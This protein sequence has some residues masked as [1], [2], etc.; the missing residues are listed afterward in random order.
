MTRIARLLLVLVAG[1]STVWAS[2]PI[3]VGGPQLG[4]DGE[5]FRWNPAAMPIRYRVDAGPM[6][7]TLNNSAGRTLVQRMFQVW[8]NV[9]TA[10]ISY[11][12]DSPILGASGILPDVSTV[13]QFNEVMGACA[14]GEQ[15]PIIFDADG[16]LM[17]A[18]G[19]EGVIGFAPI[20]S[21]DSAPDRGY[22]KT[23]AVVMN[24]K[25]ADGN[26][27]NSEASGNIF[28]VAITHELGHFSGL[29]H[30]QVNVQSF[31]QKSCAVDLLAG[32]PLMFPIPGC[33]RPTDGGGL[34]LLAVDDLASLASLYP[35][36]QTQSAYGTLSGRVFFSDGV[37]Q[38]QGANVVARRVDVPSTPE[39]ESLRIAVSSVSGYRFTGNPGQP[40]SGT[41]DEGDPTGSRNADDIGYF[42]MLVP[43][44]TYTLEVESIE[45][46]FRDGSG[47]G[48]LS[49][50]VPIP[51]LPEFW[52]EG[53]SAFDY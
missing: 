10:S 16:S 50:P 45:S 34:P 43:A 27:A 44:G 13:E 42:R 31:H 28:D 49:P 7:A 6:S 40:F 22:I 5:P 8:Q 21:V 26:L 52:N 9:P 12:Y 2:G 23:A 36:G 11:N 51:G 53:E 32:L 18:L 19:I 15:S 46:T 14:R 39:D 33:S 25:Y 29:G 35:N 3:I 37:S 4:R 41:N 47:V 30:S 48:P 38:V 24:G 20:C 17:Q 1:Y